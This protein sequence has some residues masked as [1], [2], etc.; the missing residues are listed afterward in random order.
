MLP[1]KKRVTKDLF[2]SIMKAG[3]VIQSPLFVFRYIS[4]TTPRYAFVVSKTVVKQAVLRNRLRRKGYNAL[5]Q[6]PKTPSI[7][8]IFFYKKTA[9]DAVF[10]D[11]KKDIGNILD[12]F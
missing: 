1:K 8:G 11:I 3:K 10:H 4:S 2:Q 9:K 6:Y 12:K 7:M 5:S